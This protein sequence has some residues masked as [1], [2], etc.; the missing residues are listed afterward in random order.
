MACPSVRRDC[1]KAYRHIIEM[2]TYLSILACLT[3]LV[4]S[5][6]IARAQD[7]KRVPEMNQGVDAVDASA[8]A[9]VDE[10]TVQAPQPSQEP[11]KP[12]T[13]YSRWGI[14]ASS[15]PPA[16]QYWPAHAG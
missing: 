4:I 10:V 16:T 13:T 9:G 2:K 3:T 12:P 7:G 11:V 1:G 5:C 6:G 15:Q 14:T 8:H